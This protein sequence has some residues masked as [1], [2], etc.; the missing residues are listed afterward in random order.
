[1]SSQWQLETLATSARHSLALQTADGRSRVPFVVI[2]GA[3]RT[4][5]ALMIAGAHGDEYEGPAAIHD[6]IREIEPRQI[7]GSVIFVPVAN[8]L[9]FAASTRRHPTDNGD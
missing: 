8:P 9:A 1:M 3:A 6:L 2:I 7:T 4:P 5:V